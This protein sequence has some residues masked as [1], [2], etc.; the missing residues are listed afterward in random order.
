MG[1]EDSL[2]QMVIGQLNTH[3][4]KNED[5]PLPHST[6]RKLGH[7][8]K[9]MNK[10]HKTQSIRVNLHD[11]RFGNRL[12]D[13]TPK[14]WTAK[15]KIDRLNFSKIKNFCPFK[16][17]IKK[18]LKKDTEWDKPFSNHIWYEICIYNKQYLELNNKKI[19]QF[20]HVQGFE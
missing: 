15:E 19:A 13:M 9:C 2:Q 12:W 18:A 4:P 14:A 1:K 5:G 11:F 7:R 3:I 17:I 16:D 10:N 6:D 8:L 20:E